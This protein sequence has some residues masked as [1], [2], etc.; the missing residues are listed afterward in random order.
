MVESH[1]GDFDTNGVTATAV[2][3]TT[4]ARRM[5]SARPYNPGF[6]GR[7]LIPLARTKVLC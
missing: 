3:F 2:L 7:H 4:L 5:P 6:R 1:V